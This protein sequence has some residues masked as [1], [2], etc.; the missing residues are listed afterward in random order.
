MHL[1]AH[2]GQTAVGNAG[3]VGARDPDGPALTDQLVAEHRSAPVRAGGQ[4]RMSTRKGERAR[5]ASRNGVS[6]APTAPAVRSWDA[7]RIV[8]ALRAE[9]SFVLAVVVIG[10][11]KLI[12]S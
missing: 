5:A 1:V 8:G 12:A 7:T 6:S 4:E 2:A 10:L 9:G 3:E 11:V